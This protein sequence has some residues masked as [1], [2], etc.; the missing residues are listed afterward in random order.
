MDYC[1][2]CGAP[3]P[4]DTRWKIVRLFNPRPPWCRPATEECYR[5]LAKRMGFTPTEKDIA[6]ALANAKRVRG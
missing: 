1:I 3:L 4:E 2:M 6:E 5:G